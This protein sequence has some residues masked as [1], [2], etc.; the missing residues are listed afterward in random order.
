[1]AV[2]H[3]VIGIVARTGIDGFFMGNTAKRFSGNS[4]ALS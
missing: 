2:D 4:T 3:I 1:M